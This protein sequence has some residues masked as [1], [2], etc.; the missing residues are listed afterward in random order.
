MAQI[1]IKGKGP[2]A[3]GAILEMSDGR[4]LFQL[5]DNKK[6]IHYPGYWSIFTGAL[7][8]SD[9]DGELISSL[10][11][12]ILRELSEEL[13]ILTKEGEIPFVP[14]SDIKILNECL[15][16]DSNEN[17]ADYQYV[18]HVNVDIPSDKFVLKEGQKLGVFGEKEIN[19]LNI[20]PSYREIIK[21]FFSDKKKK[22]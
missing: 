8:E 19:Q 9:W 6:G 16:T 2:I 1:K 5:R 15:Y 10:K 17:Y 21:K 12:G 13:H 22:S 4:V 18:F 7:E 14:Q 3:I 20:A 11:K